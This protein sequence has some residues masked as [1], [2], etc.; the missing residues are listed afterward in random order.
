MSVICLLCLLIPSYSV[1]QRGTVTASL[2]VEADSIAIG[3]PLQ[4]SITVS[5]PSEAIIEFP[6]SRDFSPFGLIRGTATPTRTE[7]GLSLDEVEYEIRTFSLSPKQQLELPILWY[8]GQDTGQIRLLSDTF[9]LKRQIQQ[10]NDSMEYRYT[11]TPVNLED[12][13]NYLSFLLLTFFALMLVSLL[14]FAL[15]KPA[16]RYWALRNLNRSTERM[17][18]SLERLSKEQNQ[19]IQLETL[20]TLWRNYLDPEQKIQLGAMT[21]TELSEGV[22]KLPYLNIEDQKALLEAARLR[23][24]VSFAG[25]TVGYATI[26]D[27]FTAF[28]RVVDRVY[29]H[30]KS[31]IQG[32]K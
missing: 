32:D 11:L 21:T 30:R 16:R 13:P 26:G 28:Q 6:T 20:N 31:L 24:Q 14:V 18:K 10:V 9:S 25:H 3:E 17:R 2:S 4:I 1:A 19:E 5:H 22:Q 12:P 29:Q 15:R 7:G 27:T 23:D 8:N